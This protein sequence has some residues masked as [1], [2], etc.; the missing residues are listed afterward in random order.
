M[1]GL[2]GTGPVSV[3]EYRFDRD[4]NSPFRLMRA[5]RDRPATAGAAD[6]ARQ[7]S[8]LRA[9][10]LG[11]VAAQHQALGTLEKLGPSMLQA[12]APALMKLAGEAKD[13]QVREAAR[14]VI[15][16]ALTPPAYSRAE[17]EE[18]RRTCECRPTDSAVRSREADG[19]LRLATRL[20][21]NGCTFL[22]IEPR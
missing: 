19:R 17:V 7:A 11:D 9:L 22:I 13:P 15:R 16:K 10:E 14:E 2:G 20:A 21:G 8:A 1:A 5:L 6:R 12:A 4:H 3:Q 18:V